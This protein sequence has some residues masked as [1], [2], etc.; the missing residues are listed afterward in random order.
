MGT[1]AVAAPAVAASACPAC[2]G[3]SGLG[4]GVY[5]EQADPA[6]PPMIAAAQERIAAFYGGREN[7]PRV[8]ICATGACY[9]RIGEG[10]EK[11][12]ALT[13]GVARASR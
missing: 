6:Y 1:V 8:L 2:Y 12:Q 10:G 5:A 11:G 3:L 9:R 7:R 13:S 4:D